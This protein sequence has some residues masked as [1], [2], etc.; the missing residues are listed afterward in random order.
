MLPV[1]KSTQYN[2]GGC[3]T[4]YCETSP[5]W[6]LSQ[7]LRVVK[8]EESEGRH[9]ARV[10]AA[11]SNVLPMGPSSRST[12]RKPPV[13][14]IPQPGSDSDAAGLG[15]EPPASA[16]KEPAASQSAQHK[17]DGSQ[18]GGHIVSKPR[19][20]QQLEKPLAAVANQTVGEIQQQMQGAPQGCPFTPSLCPSYCCCMIAHAARCS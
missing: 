3:L 17:G 13:I 1:Y 18:L 2:K 7:V 16:R 20:R 9:E 5:L 4:A 15:P 14:S 6:L 19:L 10:V 8:A 12:P 11:R